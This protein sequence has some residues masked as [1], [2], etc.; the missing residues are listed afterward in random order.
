MHP[1]ILN[2]SFTQASFLFSPFNIEPDFQLTCLLYISPETENR[3]I[4][5]IATVF[6]GRIEEWGGLI[7]S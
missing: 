1:I 5:D 4:N 6:C 7:G 3:P 2:L